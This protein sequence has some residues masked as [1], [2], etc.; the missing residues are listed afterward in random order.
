MSRL[1]LELSDEIDRCLTDIARRSGLSKGEAI[2][3]AFAL[4]S[5]AD[6]EE[7]KGNFL[8]VVRKNKENNQLE[9]VARLVGI[10]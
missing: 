6:V 7:N 2:R 4:L 1:T 5:I 10:F 3:R 9:T 8:A